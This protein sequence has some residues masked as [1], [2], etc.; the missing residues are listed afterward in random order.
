MDGWT[1]GWIDGSAEDKVILRYS[2]M[3]STS[4]K[5]GFI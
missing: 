2:G 1:D 3:I 5:G 4:G